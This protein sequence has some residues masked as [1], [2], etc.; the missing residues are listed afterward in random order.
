M[1]VQCDKCK[2]Y[3]DDEFRFTFCPHQAFNANDGNNN[4]KVHNDAY[5]SK[6]PPRG[7]TPQVSGQ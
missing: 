4:F 7:D 6:D 1:I 5:I 2:V 3:Y